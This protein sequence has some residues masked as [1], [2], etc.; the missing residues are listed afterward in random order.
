MLKKNQL[1]QIFQLKIA[2]FA[3]SAVINLIINPRAILALNTGDPY[4]PP[5][6]DSIFGLIKPPPGV[7]EY[8]DAAGGKIGIIVFLSNII[9][10]V[11]IA[12][13]VWTMFNIILAG[14]IYL[15]SSG[16]ASAHEKVSSKL[17]NS[18]IG[19]A[20]VAF[21]YTIAA[22]IGFIIFGDAGYIINPDI[23]TINDL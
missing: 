2:V 14:W 13:G 8:Q 6:N 21:A 5:A 4:V 17:I 20:L 15:T 19:L 18:V 22:A 16:D 1:V 11:T 23:T 3:I 10:L 9:R 12:A 7:A